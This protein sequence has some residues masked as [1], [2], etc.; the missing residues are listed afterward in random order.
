MG[1]TDKPF[2]TNSSEQVFECPFFS[3]DKEEFEHTCTGD[4]GTYYVT[5]HTPCASIIPM[6]ADG[7]FT[8]VKQYRYIAQQWSIEFPC[9]SVD[10]GEEPLET[11]KREL[12]EEC[13]LSAGNYKKI[14]R[15]ASSIGA[16]DSFCTVFLATDLDALQDHTTD[17]VL[18]CIEVLNLT[19]D[20]I[21]QLIAD[22]KIFDGLTLSAW[23]FYNAQ[24]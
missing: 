2:T 12:G 4:H 18:E 22:G 19:H 21:T 11:A 15:F 17:D 24:R 23:S 1:K 20:E 5:R 3:I 14:G 9:G 10:A 16:L 7:T 8:M 13:Q 6:N